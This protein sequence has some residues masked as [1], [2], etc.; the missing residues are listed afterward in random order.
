[1]GRYMAG[2]KLSQTAEMSS[3][4]ASQREGFFTSLR[5]IIAEVESDP[6]YLSTWKGS[7]ACGRLRVRGRVDRSHGKVR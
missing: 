7:V 3:S 1:M 2:A 5:D 4:T 6:V